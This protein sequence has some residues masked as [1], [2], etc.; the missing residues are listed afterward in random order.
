[1]GAELA[2]RGVTVVCGGWEECAPEYKIDRI[3]FPFLSIEFVAAGAGEVVLN[4]VRHALCPGTVF[5]YGPEVRHEIRNATAHRLGKYFVDV[6]GERAR[7]LLDECQL[8]PGTAAQLTATGEVRQAFDALIR[9]AEGNHALAR[10]MCALQVEVLVLAISRSMQPATR[11][12]R[13]AR[14][15]FEAA[16]ACHIAVAHLCRLFRRF[17][18]ETPFH[19]LQRLQMEWAAERLHASGR[20]IRE[21]ADELDVDAFQFSRTFKRIHGISPSGF[22]STRG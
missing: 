20:L 9:F 10:R 22:L 17:H 13:R 11:S 14:A 18:G 7:H 12:E 1:M 6:V 15:T 2:R 3:S 5:T 16:A 4:G 19:Y 8:S 21:V